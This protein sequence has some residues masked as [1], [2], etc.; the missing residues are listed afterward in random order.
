MQYSVA[1]A[2]AY[3]PRRQ[4]LPAAQQS[5]GKRVF[6]GQPLVTAMLPASDQ[7][8][9][10]RDS[11]GLSAQKLLPDLFVSEEL[12]AGALEGVVTVYQH[13]APVCPL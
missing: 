6:W 4:P 5:T 7:T 10:R 2:E 13:V 8:P 12:R 1:V 9:G 3:Q 11:G